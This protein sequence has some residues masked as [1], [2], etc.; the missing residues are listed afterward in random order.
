[1]CVHYRKLS[2]AGPLLERCV[3][4]PILTAETIARSAGEPV[5]NAGMPLIQE[6]L[7]RQVDLPRRPVNAPA[8]FRLLRGSSSRQPAH[9]R[10]ASL[11]P[12]HGPAVPLKRV[13]G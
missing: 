12:V 4:S 9:L 1:M 5:E 7:Q 10:I 8:Q 13:F 11:D 6:L 3:Q 2:Y